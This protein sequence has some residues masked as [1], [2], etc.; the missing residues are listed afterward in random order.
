MTE[1]AVGHAPGRHLGC[2]L[3][4]EQQG[5]DAPRFAGPRPSA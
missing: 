5:S 4:C 1:D 2:D 3:G